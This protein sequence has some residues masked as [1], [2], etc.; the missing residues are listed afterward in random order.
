MARSAAKPKIAKPVE[1]AWVALLPFPEY[2]ST[3]ALTLPIRVM[4][5]EDDAPEREVKNPAERS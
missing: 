3:D 4:P 5:Q 2:E 1:G